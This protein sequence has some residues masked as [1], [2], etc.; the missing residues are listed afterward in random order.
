MR[1]TVDDM[2]RLEYEYT[3]KDY[4]Y[5]VTLPVRKYYPEDYEKSDEKYPVMLFFHGYG[6][7]GHENEKQIRVLQKPNRLLD[8]LVETDKCIIIAPQ[9]F[10]P[11]EFNWVGINHAWNTG[12]RDELPEKPNI[13]LKAAMQILFDEI[14]TNRVDTSRIYVAGISMGGYA[15]WEALARYPELFAAAV[16]VCGSGIR[17]SCKDLVKTGIMAFHGKLD[18]TVPY[19]GTKE[20]VDTISALGNDNCT[21]T[22]F[23]GVGHDSWNAAYATPGLIDWLLSQHR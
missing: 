12:N 16:P 17:S 22:Y 21:G 15:C 14:E 19:T 6:E 9:C 18:G 23:D 20:M 5:N 1:K 7:I 11:A 13:S 4:T 2:I 10:D 3:D 8:M